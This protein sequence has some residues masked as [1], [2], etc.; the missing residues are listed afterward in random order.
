MNVTLAERVEQALFDMTHAAQL[1]RSP[2]V[3]KAVRAAKKGADVERSGFALELA[4]QYGFVTLDDDAEIY[5]C[6]AEVLTD[7]M[8]VL[9]FRTRREREAASIRKE[10]EA[11]VQEVKTVPPS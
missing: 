5:A 7:L 6:S 11:L 1:D 2:E 10:H 8:S 4:D 3:M 9:G